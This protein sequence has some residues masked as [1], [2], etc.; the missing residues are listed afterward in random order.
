MKKIISCIISLLFVL[1][2]VLPL[3]IECIEENREYECIRLPIISDQLKETVT[4]DITLYKENDILYVPLHI[5]CPLI[6]AYWN[7]QDGGFIVDRDSLSFRYY[8]ENNMKLIIDFERGD[9]KWNKTDNILLEGNLL[10]CKKFGVEWCVDFIKFCDMFGATFYQVYQDNIKSVKEDIQKTLSA[11]DKNS[12][13]DIEIEKEL[14][15]KENPY[16]IF[17]Y[18]GVPLSSFYDKIMNNQ[19]VY[20]WDYSYYENLNLSEK[21]DNWFKKLLKDVQYSEVTKKLT[22]QS[23]N[24]FSNVVNDDWGITKILLSPPYKSAEHYKNSL[25]DISGVNYSHYLNKNDLEPE[26]NRKAE[27]LQK[28][29]NLGT[30]TSSI[31]STADNILKKY[32]NDTEM[33]G[34]LNTILDIINISVTPYQK[35]CEINEFNNKLNSINETKINLL[36][37]SIIE[38]DFIN[39]NAKRQGL[40]NDTLNG[41]SIEIPLPNDNFNGTFSEIPL[42][43]TTRTPMFNIMLNSVDNYEGLFNSANNLCSLYKNSNKQFAETLYKTVESGVYAIGDT[44]INNTLSESGDPNLEL[45]SAIITV[46][47]GFTAWTKENYG[48]QLQKSENLVQSYFVEK[49]MQKSLDIKN[50]ENLYN[51][52]TLML[53]SSLCCFEYDEKYFQSN[54][55]SIA[56]MLYTLDINTSLNINYYHDPRNNN[57]DENIKNAILNFSNNKVE[58]TETTTETTATTTETTTTTTNSNIIANGICGDNL[59]WTLYTTGQ[60]TISGTDEMYDYTDMGVSWREYRKDIKDVVISGDVTYIGENAFA[61]CE[62]LENINLPDGL[63]IISDSCFKGCKS[64]KSISIPESVT[65]LGLS[66]FKDCEQLTNIKLPDNLKEI[67]FWAFKDCTNLIDIVIPESVE[68]LRSGTFE[69]CSKLK[70]IIIPNSIKNISSDTFAYCT[71]LTSITI[72][73]DVAIDGKNVFYK[74]PNVV[75]YGYSGTP[76]EKYANNNNIPFV[77]LNNNNEQETTEDLI[78][79]TVTLTNDDIKPEWEH[80]TSLNLEYP[81]FKSKDTELQDFLTTSVT[82]KI[83]SY[84]ETNSDYNVSIYGSFKY[85]MSVNGY[86]SIST[87]IANHAEGG[88]GAHTIP[89]TFFLDLQNKKILSLNDLFSE[90]EDEIYKEVAIK[91]DKYNK[92]HAQHDILLN[93]NYKEC[94]FILTKD[95]LILTFNP[96]SISV[97]AEGIINIEIPLTDLNLTCTIL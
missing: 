42:P 68:V 86:L 58:Q 10:S 36:K 12:W 44:F 77:E 90:T 8:D 84:M 66:A 29:L 97:G 59:T 4:E 49:T 94:K 31:S 48:E 80:V 70:S 51:R 72:A 71:S 73:K 64:L 54:R 15:F 93:Y 63:T 53:Q 33:F 88:N 56:K 35:Y 11:T 76:A 67:D 41:I 22:I 62:N 85:D 26:N 9:E 65:K 43:S 28:L 23:Q 79:E 18:S 78:I 50:P 74:T 37:K 6:N 24:G 81:V 83:L 40:L 75:I 25:I 17:V 2:M 20:L 1:N 13:N 55:N 3:S 7:V 19:D 61:Y 69:K 39:K 95:N 14:D 87:Y 16:Y 46:Y 92:S 5:V 34:K 89:Y 52:L 60:L 91:A 32:L 57:V 30:I 21:E 45:V 27:E 96:Y 38:N 47:D 82:E